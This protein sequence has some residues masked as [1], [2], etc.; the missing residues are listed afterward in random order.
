MKLNAEEYAPASGRLIDEGGN[1]VN[2]VSLLGGAAPVSAVVHDINA[3][4][5][6]S[7]RVI[8]EDGKL[9]NLVD[10]LAGFGGSQ[11]QPPTVPATENIR[12]EATGDN[13]LTV[14][15]NDAPTGIGAANLDTGSFAIGK[16]YCIYLN[17]ETVIIS[18]NAALSH[19]KIGG[20]HYGVNR[21]TNSVRQ[22]INAA[23][24]TKGTGWEAN[25]Y[26]GIVPRSIWTDSHRPRC[27]PEGMVLAKGG[28][29]GLA[30]R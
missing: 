25:I 29:R 14:Y 3:Y 18:L 11:P 26:N 17:N 8:G 13:A 7:G 23:G 22:P 6:R 12:I 30:G 21:R 10:L 5:P 28:L 9:Y 1:I 19:R 15:R 16:N 20:F 4:T 2:I 24:E 27:S